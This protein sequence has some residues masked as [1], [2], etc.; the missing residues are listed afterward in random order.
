MSDCSCSYCI[1]IRAV[2]RNAK[3]AEV[4][5]AERDA[6]RGRV[7]AMLSDIEAAWGI[8]ANAG[9]GDWLKE[10]PEWVVAAMKWRDRYHATLRSLSPSGATAPGGGDGK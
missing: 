5:E 8:I 10:S 7:A 2:E 1:A 9:G 4:A 3:L 6:L